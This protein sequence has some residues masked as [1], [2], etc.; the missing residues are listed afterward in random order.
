MPIKAERTL[1]FETKKVNRST[2]ISDSLID[3]AQE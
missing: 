3:A 1:A 2:F